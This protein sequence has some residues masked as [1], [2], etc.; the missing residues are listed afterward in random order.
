[1][2][3]SNIDDTFEIVARGN[4]HVL[5]YLKDQ[6]ETYSWLQKYCFSAIQYGQMEIL[7]WLKS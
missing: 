6:F 5:E 7:K 2:I 1:M 4:L 3:P